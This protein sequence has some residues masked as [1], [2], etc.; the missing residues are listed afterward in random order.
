MSSYRFSDNTKTPLLNSA[1]SGTN[2]YS[3]EI[4]VT[5]FESTCFQAEWTG[6]PTGTI[7]IL[8][9]LDGVNFRDFGASVSTQPAGSASGVLIPI[10]ASCMKYL[11]LSYTNA[12]GSGNLKVMAVSKTR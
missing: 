4:E 9:S 6:S 8:G 10:Y 11:Q 1:V 7:S 12:S 2:T 3:C 5:S